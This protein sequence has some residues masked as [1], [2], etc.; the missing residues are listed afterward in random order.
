MQ[1]NRAI[2]QTLIYHDI[3][4][5][6]LT[7]KQLTQYLLV[8]SEIDQSLSRKGR[9]KNSGV[10]RISNTSIVVAAKTIGAY[11]NGYFC[12]K[13]REDIIQ[14]RLDMQADNRG[15]KEFAQKIAHYLSYVPTVLFIGISGAVA[16]ENAEK[17]DDIDLF[18]ITGKNTMWTTR[19]LVTVLLDMKGLRRKR[20]SKELA[21]KI[22]LNFFVDET[23]LAFPKE[24][25]D[26]YIAHEIVQVV[27]LINKVNTYERLLFLNKWILQ[28]MPNSFNKYNTVHPQKI[29]IKT[30]AFSNILQSITTRTIVSLLEKSCRMLQHNY[31]KKHITSETIDKNQLAFHPIDYRG[32]VLKA[33]KKRIKIYT[34]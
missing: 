11:R 8:S 4:D 34:T 32:K 7:L 31:M 15:K 18:I 1:L 9:S 29:G 13:G 16:M 28:Y 22:C 27:P 17:N 3:F 19:L 5:Y 24:K 20:S 12:L 26:I 33:Y 21:N 6:C 30:N 23:A 10:G 2:L 14:K 25:Q